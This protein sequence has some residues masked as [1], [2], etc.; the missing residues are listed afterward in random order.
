MRMP[1]GISSLSM[2]RSD[3]RTT[4]ESHRG[5]SSGGFTTRNSNIQAGERASSFVTIGE[6]LVNPFSSQPHS[7]WRRA[8]ASHARGNLLAGRHTRTYYPP[9]HTA[10]R[11]LRVHVDGRPSFFDSPRG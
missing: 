6:T 1:Y 2:K 5:S 4:L 11:W 10:G 7:S 9:D 3:L 8:C